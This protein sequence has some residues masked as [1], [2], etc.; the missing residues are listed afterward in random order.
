VTT[1]IKITVEFV[2]KI[3]AKDRKTLSLIYKDTYPMVEKYI[4]QNSGSRDDA[5]DVFQDAMYV[6]IK[7]SE[8]PEFTLTAKVSTFV[9]GITKNL[10]LKQ[11]SKNK[12]DVEAL[13]IENEFD[14]TPTV[15]DTKNL[16]RVKRMKDCLYQ[17]GEPCKTILEHF[18]FLKTPMKRIAEMLHYTNANNAKNQKYK[19]FMRLKKMMTTVAT[20]K[21]P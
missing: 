10:W 3:K 5:Q 20:E 15:T 6:L 7:K 21:Q 16:E 13:Q 18:Y 11:L 8:D 9:F 19:C 14:A 4:L 2:D 1:D 17:L 12:L